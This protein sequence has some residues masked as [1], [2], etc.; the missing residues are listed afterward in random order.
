MPEPFLSE[1]A[2]ALFEL[3]ETAVRARHL[4]ELSQ[5][6]LPRL[7]KITGALVALIYVADPRVSTTRFFGTGVSPEAAPGLEN[8]CAGTCRKFSVQ[9][10]LERVQ[11]PL[12]PAAPARLTL[13]PL[14]AAAKFLGVL[15]LALPEDQTAGAGRLV[16]IVL[17][18]L[19]HHLHQLLDLEDYEKHLA[20][21]NAYLTVSSMIA[22][23]LDLHE[24][25]ETILS[26]CMD[27]VGAEAASVLLLEEDK[28]NF[29]FYSVVG[30]ARDLLMTVAFPADRGLSG[31]VLQSQKSEVINDVQRDPRFYGRFDQE[32]GFHTR[33]MIILPLTAGE[34]KVG[35]LEVLNKRAGEAFT[36]DERLLLDSIAEEIA[37]A[38]RNAKI[39]EYVANT[40]CKQRQGQNSC[41]GC[42]RPLGS[43]TPCVKYREGLGV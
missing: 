1:E 40:Y 16:E 23:P 27:A 5:G 4:T 28:V 17:P 29:R 30:S 12:G 35:L 8:L 20:H 2:C 14:R 22:Q 19:A 25:L 6:L 36:E 34:E 32:T 39:F 43:W 10:D 21:L 9:A 24:L 11:L 26:C 31:Y 33:N 13:F 42:Q 41:K 15:G 38:I 7:A 37:F 18:V 3:A